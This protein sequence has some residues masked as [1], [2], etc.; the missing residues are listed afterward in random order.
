MYKSE[1]IFKHL[2]PNEK[3]NIVFVCM[4][5]FIYLLAK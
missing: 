4:H 2:S 1:V 3:G 5:V